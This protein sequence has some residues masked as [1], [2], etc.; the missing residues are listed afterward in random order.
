MNED[1]ITVKELEDNLL[2]RLS[3]PDANLIEDIELMGAGLRFSEAH[4]NFYNISLGEGQEDNALNSLSKA[5]V[6]GNGLLF[7]IYI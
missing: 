6:K 5:A 3:R 1:K 2:S 4:G 7:K